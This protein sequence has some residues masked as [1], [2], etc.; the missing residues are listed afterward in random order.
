MLSSASPSPDYQ[1]LRHTLATVA[2]RAEK[3]LRDVD[4]TFGAYQCG[5]SSRTPLAIVAHMGDLFDWALSMAQGTMAWHD[6][7]PVAMNEEVR[8]FFASLRLLDDYLRS[9]QPLAVSPERLFQGPVADALTHIGQIAYLRR[10][11][12]DPVRGENYFKAEIAAG[13]VGREQG[14]ERMEFE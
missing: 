2:Y 12:G 5:A 13:C 1:F 10:L 3:V 6:S 9:G 4:D 14:G 8:R 7:V 11:A